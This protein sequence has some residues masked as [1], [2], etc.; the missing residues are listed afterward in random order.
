MNTETSLL[1]ILP[2]EL[3]EE[4]EAVVLGRVAHQ[5]LNQNWNYHRKAIPIEF[6]AEYFTA[7]IATFKASQLISAY[8]ETI[9]N[10]RNRDRAMPVNCDFVILAE[11]QC[12]ATESVG[13]S[14]NNGFSFNFKPMLMICYIPAEQK[15]VVSRYTQ[16]S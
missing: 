3:E 4:N 5:L 2:L 1:P 11:M 7:K 12:G 10:R 6:S 9:D 15:V 14:R 13:K 16:S 8:P